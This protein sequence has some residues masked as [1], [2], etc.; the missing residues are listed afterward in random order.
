MRGK[1]IIAAALIAAGIGW[2]VYLALLAPAWANQKAVMR[3]RSALAKQAADWGWVKEPGKGLYPVGV[4]P[5]AAPGVY[6][7]SVSGVFEAAEAESQTVYLDSRRGYRIGVR[8]ENPAG[9]E[10]P[11]FKVVA[12]EGR[13]YGGR[14]R[15]ASLIELAQSGVLAPGDHVSLAWEESRRLAD[16]L[17]VG[18]E[19]L[20]IRAE[21]IRR[22]I[23]TGPEPQALKEAVWE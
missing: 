22:I 14:H 1:L 4:G 2:L 9:V 19:G 7:Y 6:E 3:L 18:W 20:A 10:L 16:I 17:A 11:V 5:G 23:D 21:D 12:V 8:I 15:P 13:A